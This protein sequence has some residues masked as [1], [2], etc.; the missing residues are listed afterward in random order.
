[1][2]NSLKS[3]Y[4]LQTRLSEASVV[5]CPLAL[6]DV[7]WPETLRLLPETSKSTLSEF[8]AQRT[9]SMSWAQEVDI[10][11]SHAASE[12]LLSSILNFD[13]FSKLGAFSHPLYCNLPYL[14]IRPVCLHAGTD[15]VVLKQGD[16][17][18][19][20]PSELEQ[21]A[22]AIEPLFAAEGLKLIRSSLAS[23]NRWFLTASGD[24]AAPD[25]SGFFT[26]KSAD[27]EQALGRNIDA[28]MA[29]GEF[30]RR[31]RRLE[32]EI[33]MTWFDHPI[34]LHL[35]DKGKN[36]MNSIWLEGAVHNLPIKP[37]YLQGLHSAKLPLNQLAQ[38]WSVA[39]G[40][41]L[42]Q[43]FLKP[44][45]L[46][47]YEKWNDRLIGDAIGWLNAWN[48]F[49][50]VYLE[51]PLLKN[52]TIVLTGEKQFVTLTHKKVSATSI[53]GLFASFKARVGIK[54]LSPAQAQLSQVLGIHA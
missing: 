46:H 51:N 23:E 48:E 44:G 9:I 10:V 15:H 6:P 54:S 20:N 27:S 40:A 1:M 36:S 29:K 49:I 18:D 35:A 4:N 47:V 17:I 12:Q 39:Q 21:L 25:A 7:G 28:Y 50:T 33:Q 11:Q 34:N 24:A 30:S 5:I 16:T 37:S 43:E 45:H 2:P 53:K 42:T 32:T 38:F 3:E 19:L 14:A 31:W 52:T 41:V 8:L 22:L 13:A 26:L